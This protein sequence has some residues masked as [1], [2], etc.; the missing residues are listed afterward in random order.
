VCGVN[1]FLS[2]TT[3]ILMWCHKCKL[4]G[5]PFPIGFNGTHAWIEKNCFV[6]SIETQ[7]LEERKQQMWETLRDYFDLVCVKSIF[8]M[9]DNFLEVLLTRFLIWCRMIVYDIGIPY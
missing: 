8:Y 7:G 1:P 6:F 2:R 3:T 5:A 4:I 9:G